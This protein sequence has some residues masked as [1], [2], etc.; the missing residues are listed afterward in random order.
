MSV[1]IDLSGKVALEWRARPRFGYGHAPTRLEGGN[2]TVVARSDEGV[3]AF[4]SWNAGSPLASARVLRTAGR[5]SS[6]TYSRTI[7]MAC[8]RGA[9]VLSVCR[10]IS[11]HRRGSPSASRS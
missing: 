10:T 5:Y 8:S 4:A 1:D 3:V 2:G 9:S 6:V 7:R 11:S